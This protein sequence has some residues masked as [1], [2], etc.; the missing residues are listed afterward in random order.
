MQVVIFSE[1]VTAAA[2]VAAAGELEAVT[3][4]PTTPSLIQHIL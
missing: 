3:T 2:A 1:L 4:T